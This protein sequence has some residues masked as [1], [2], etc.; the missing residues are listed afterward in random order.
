MQKR[1]SDVSRSV[2]NEDC[3]M[4]EIRQ[5]MN[6]VDSSEALEL[7]NQKSHHLWGSRNAGIIDG[8]AD[9]FQTRE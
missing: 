6:C 8:E 2:Y 5:M 9:T 1:L 7:T 3:R 4:Q